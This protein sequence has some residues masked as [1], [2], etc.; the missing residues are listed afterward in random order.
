MGKQ[1]LNYDAIMVGPVQ[2]PG[3]TSIMWVEVDKDC[4]LNS[5]NQFTMPGKLA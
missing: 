5:E 4:I 1:R 2:D 3:C